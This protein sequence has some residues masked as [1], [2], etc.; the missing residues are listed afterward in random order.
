MRR[1]SGSLAKDA[2]P[3]KFA[4]TARLPQPGLFF[5]DRQA[6]GCVVENHFVGRAAGG[7]RRWRSELANERTR[8][9]L[10]LGRVG[11]ADKSRER[12]PRTCTQ[13]PWQRENSLF[14][15]GDLA[16][17]FGDDTEFGISKKSRR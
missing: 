16:T 9:L 12:K 4:I 2:H 11:H 1:I 14:Q 3:I 5:A 15:D 6:W 8:G 17:I 10:V 13:H 7:R